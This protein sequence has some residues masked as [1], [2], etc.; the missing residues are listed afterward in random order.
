ML[1]HI[2]QRDWINKNMPKR[3][4]GRGYILS[5]M[6]DADWCVCPDYR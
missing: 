1:K 2:M 4:Y 5:H 3:I 6:A